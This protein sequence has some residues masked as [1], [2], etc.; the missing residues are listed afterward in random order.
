MSPSLA[1]VR[2]KI[3]QAEF[4]FATDDKPHALMMAAQTLVSLLAKGQ[5][6]NVVG[7][8]AA[9]EG[10]FGASDAEGAWRWKDAYEALEAAQVLFLRRYGP[11]MFARAENEPS[12]VLAMLSKIGALLP[13]ETRRSEESHALQQFSTPLEFA[14]VASLAAG[15]GAGDIVLEPSAGTGMLA[16][17]A[18]LAGAKLVLNE[19]AET[20][21]DLLK[22]L[23]PAAPLS[24]FDGAQLHDR[25]DA[26]LV[27]SVVLMNPPFSSSPLIEGR[28]AAATFEHIRASLARLRTGGR[29]VAITGESF[30]PTSNSWRGS[31]ERLQE[32]G[33]LVFT[34]SLARGFF[35]R[36]GTSV[37]SRLT[38]FDK[39]PAENPK[40]FPVGFGPIAGLSELLA[41]VQREVP[42]RALLVAGTTAEC[43]SPGLG[44]V[45]ATANSHSLARRG[46]PPRIAARVHGVG[47]PCPAC[48]RG[49]PCP[50][51][52]R[53]VC[54]DRRARL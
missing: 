46:S 4:S 18:E 20:R 40:E 1:A 16:I 30:A 23:F 42:P 21:A 44:G 13:S 51:P 22:L 24:R 19:W 3:A 45:G 7:L 36:H 41:L 12:R 37:E 52:A 38:V 50:C 8:R 27:P 17:H 29:L 32:Q 31:F 28:H 10:A 48:E 11:A 39:T 43:A 15:L 5:A 9:M 14:Y 47:A 35:A 54:R 25:L 2:S 53:R 26:G 49:R 34:A 33:R 6:I